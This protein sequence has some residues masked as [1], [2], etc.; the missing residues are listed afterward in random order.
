MSINADGLVG[1]KFF[2]YSLAPQSQINWQQL[3]LS[4]RKHGT[5]DET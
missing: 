5:G 1:S 2:R 4:R 3:P